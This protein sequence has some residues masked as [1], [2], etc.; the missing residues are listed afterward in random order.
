MAAL[1]PRERRCPACGA[2]QRGGGRRCE[3]CGAD[4]T[5]RFAQGRSRRAWVF[6]AIVGLVLAAIAVPVVAGMRDDAAGERQRAAERQ[7]RLRA[8][9]R[10]RQER[11]AVPVRATAP[12]GAPGAD[13]LTRREELVRFGEEQITADANRRVAEGTLKGDHKGTSCEI[14]PE[15]QARRAAEADPATLRGRY[16]CVAYTSQIEG[17]AGNQAVFGDPFWLVIDY[18]RGSLVWCKVTP[19]A[20]EGGS[21]LVTVPV[22]APCRDPEGAG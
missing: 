20:G 9:E 11:D 2:V 19:R 16:D 14:F 8:A 17:N 10:A 4:L 18:E 12:A 15:T 13:A 22:P 6:A 7:E 21:V 1:A 3:N 5:A